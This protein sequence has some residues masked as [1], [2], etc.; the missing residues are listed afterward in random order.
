MAMGFFA[1]K[2]TVLLRRPWVMHSAGIVVMA[3]GVL[4]LYQSLSVMMS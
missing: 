4:Y 2:L 1:G 3:I